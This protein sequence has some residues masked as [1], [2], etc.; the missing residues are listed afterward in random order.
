MPIQSQRPNRLTARDLPRPKPTGYGTDRP[1][2]P[3]APGA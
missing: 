3:H 2:P 1:R